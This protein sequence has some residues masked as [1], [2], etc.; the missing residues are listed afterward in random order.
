MVNAAAARLTE[1]E[2]AAWH[3]YAANA[4]GWAA[5]VGITAREFERLGLRGIART[6]W[7]NAMALIDRETSAAGADE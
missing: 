5:R 6:L 7:I 1:F 2:A 3:W 4:S